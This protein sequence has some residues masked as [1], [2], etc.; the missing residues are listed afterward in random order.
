MNHNQSSIHITKLNKATSSV[1]YQLQQ[2]IATR[3]ALNHGSKA[4]STTSQAQSVNPTQSDFKPTQPKHQFLQD[5]V[6]NLATSLPKDQV[7]CLFFQKKEKKKDRKKIKKERKR[8]RL[9]R[10][11]LHI[12]KGT[13]GNSEEFTHLMIPH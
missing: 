13:F 3:Y 5:Y 4:Q 1:S 10:E 9:W 11:N 7:S 8:V 2:R 12:S 6:K